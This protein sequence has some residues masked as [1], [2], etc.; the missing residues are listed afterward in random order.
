MAT[1][2][3]TQQ[4]IDGIR[5]RIAARLLCA[6]D[7]L[8][9]VRQSAARFGVSPATVVEAYDRLVADGVI[10]AVPRSGFSLATW[11]APRPA[12]RP[13]PPP[14][15]CDRSVLGFAPVAGRER[16][17]GDAGLRLAAGGLDAAGGAAT[18]SA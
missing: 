7:R 6:G 18:R 14:R 4:V 9:S 5:S 13:T 15:P 17:G 16:R 3:R 8:P 1:A 2:P 12:R 11:P 10:Q